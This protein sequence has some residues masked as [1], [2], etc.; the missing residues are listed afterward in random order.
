MELPGLTI[1]ETTGAMVT[2]SLRFNS[3]SSVCQVVTQF[4]PRLSSLFTVTLS[5]FSLS[6]KRCRKRSASIT[7]HK[8]KHTTTDATQKT[9]TYINDTSNMAV[10]RLNMRQQEYVLWLA[11]GILKK[12]APNKPPGSSR[13]NKI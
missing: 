1:E 10:T 11:S 6:R 12:T 3:F 9:S 7:C 4:P 5:G 13:K 2:E 8:R